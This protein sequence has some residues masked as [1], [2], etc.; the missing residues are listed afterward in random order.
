MEDP[1]AG[2][3]SS[4]GATSENK[5]RYSEIF[6]GL[7]ALEIC[8]GNET[9][10]MLVGDI[11]N[12][13]SGDTM[14]ELPSDEA[15]MGEFHSTSEGKALSTTAVEGPDDIL[16]KCEG[17]VDFALDYAKKWCK[18][19]KELLSWMDKR[20][21]YE[22]E[23]ARNL[24]KIAE[25]GRWAIN[26]QD[27]M[28]LQYIYTMVM[29]KDVKIAT[30]TTDTAALLNGKKFSQSLIA[31]RNEIEKWRKEFREQWQRG[32]KRMN[33]SLVSLRK[34]RLQYLQRCEEAEKAKA[35]SVKAEEELQAMAG[36]NPGS[37]SKQLE[38]RRR[39]RDDALVKA[40]DAEVAYRTCVSD[41]NRH[42]QDLEKVRER[43][44]SHIRKLI[45]QGDQVLKEVTL[46]FFRL[47]HQ[48]F[49]LLPTAYQ[50]L[51]ESCQPYEVGEKYLEF[52]QRLP[53]KEL[54]LEVYEFEEFVPSGQRSP[55]AGRKKHLVHLARISSS[56]SDLYGSEEAGAGKPLPTSEQSGRGTGAKPSCSDTESLGGSSESRSLDSPTSSPGLLH[57]KLPKA[58]S[59][60]T[61]SSDD[62]DEKDATQ[63]YEND[64]SDATSE[65]GL[66]VS[67][68]RNVL[69]SRAAQTHRLR[70]L[71][72]PARCQE[73]DAFMVS[74][75]ECEECYFTCHKKCLEGVL[76]VCGHR[77]L[78]G[79]VPVFGV[80][81][82]QVSRDFPEQ[83]PFLVAKCT[84]E[85]ESRALGV[86][87]IYRISGAK[88]RV[89]KLCQAFENGRDLVELSETSPHDITTVLKLFLKQLPESVVSTQLYH[90]LI[91]FAKDLQR[92]GEDTPDDPER[93]EGGS[94][95]V[96]GM[97][98]ILCKLP[99]SNYNTIRHIIAH[100][101]R[102]AGRYKENKMNP[103]NLGIIFGPT[104]VRPSSGNDV[105]LTCL[106]DSAYQA[107]IVE[108]LIMHY[109]RIFGMDD[110]PPSLPYG[111]ENPPAEDS[112]ATVEE[113]NQ[114][115]E[116]LD[117]SEVD[118]LDEPSSCEAGGQSSMDGDSLE[119]HEQS[120]IEEFEEPVLDGQDPDPDAC[121]VGQ[122]RDHFSRQPVK[123]PRTRAAAFTLSSPGTT[124][125]ILERSPSVKSIGSSRSSSPD[126]GTLRRSRGKQ[127]T[128]QITQET[129]RIVSRFQASDSLPV[130]SSIGEQ[131]AKP[132][133]GEMSTD[134]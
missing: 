89:E 128:F 76:V 8:L 80:H 55:P 124:P 123:H 105:S 82:S 28:P 25:S 54:P 18:Y 112:T 120:S 43:T 34:A 70:K 96:Q 14:E 48:H 39:S 71:R 132:N 93:K 41:A 134:L 45:Y 109:E 52:I 49:E 83:V 29:E 26:Q 57:R 58:S 7:D 129:A 64:L 24:I 44:V 4:Q 133:S 98:N 68:F 110:L 42:R 108:F 66:S 61:V 78:P 51:T 22:C 35:L 15:L 72:G 126:S 81:F 99:A 125:E 131:T 90:E 37:A 127:K 85:I 11:S 73:C 87:G 116:G 20:L 23:F 47:Q 40:K 122:P 77:K 1:E 84:A 102:V 53:K 100:L 60:G 118:V 92:L 33:D 88:A 130:A 74:G 65:N 16:I 117:S 30:S 50:N 31:K 111:C 17:G 5:K 63:S 104:L 115:L 12:T 9:V 101:Y 3:L 91:M 69:L 32:Q 95:S 62:L 119:S 6:R 56:A 10:E 75:T 38:R 46:N 97:Q 2:G 59:T 103:N 107:Q 114:R 36:A 113:P 121:L 106:I 86:Q 27:C 21:I 67:P 19:A 79:R 13:T 94:D